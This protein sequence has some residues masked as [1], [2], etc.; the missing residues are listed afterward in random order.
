MATNSSI[1]AQRIL[2]TEEPGGLQS[3]GVIKSQTQLSNLAHRQHI[4]SISLGKEPDVSQ[5]D[6]LPITQLSRHRTTLRVV[7]VC[8]KGSQTNLKVISLSS[9]FLQGLPCFTLC[10]FY[11]QQILWEVMYMSVQLRLWFFQQSC[12]GCES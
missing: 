11:C 7:K 8:H 10:D 12:M 3:M 6:S 1:L 9:G 5:M 4:C 2:Q